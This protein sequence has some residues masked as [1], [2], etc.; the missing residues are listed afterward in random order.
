MSRDPRVDSYIARAA[1][2][3]RPILAHVRDRVHA[4][5]PEVEETIKWGHP[6]FLKQGRIMIGMAAFKAHAAVNFWRGGEIV[7]G[8]AKT[9][10][11]GQLGKLTGIADLP[12]DFDEMIVEA[13]TLSGEKAPP[14]PNKPPRPAGDL[15][16]DF[17]TALDANAAARTTF[18]ALAPSHRR[19][20]V[21][22]IN[23][24]KQDATRAKRIAT[25]V[26]W[27]AEGKKRNW[28]YEK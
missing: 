1:D 20:Y 7:G 21:E 28:K 24:A 15:H 26:E 16:P 13:A 9:G 3:A 17:V 4:L 6:S 23:D 8:E 14:K 25:A 2:F 22:W 19:D 12:A 27:L 11:M 18:D 5:V 10:A